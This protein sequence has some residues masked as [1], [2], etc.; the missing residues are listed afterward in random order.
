MRVV[1][2]STA[3]GGAPHTPRLSQEG[4]WFRWN[5]L[6]WKMLGGGGSPGHEIYRRHILEIKYSIVSSSLFFTCL[7]HR[8]Q[9]QPV[10]GRA[11]VEI[12]TRTKRGLPSNTAGRA[13]CLWILDYWLFEREG[14]GKPLAEHGSFSPFSYACGCSE[15][16]RFHSWYEYSV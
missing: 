10:R 16:L 4:R 8:K 2:I 7:R 1:P 13:N 6:A 9:C 14:R 3:N 11:I 15:G 5:V 12:R